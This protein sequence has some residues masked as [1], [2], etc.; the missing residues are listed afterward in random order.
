MVAEGPAIA[1]AS[2]SSG[3]PLHERELFGQRCRAKPLPRGHELGATV[4]ELEPENSLPFHFHQGS[5]GGPMS[6]TLSA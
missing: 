5:I 6:H 4:Y 2:L 3:S 1:P